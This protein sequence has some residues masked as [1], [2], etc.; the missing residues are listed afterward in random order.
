MCRWVAY[1]GRPVYLETWLTAPCQSLVAQSRHCREAKSE[2]NADGF[3]VGWY[4]GR[5][6]PG[7]FRDIRPAWSDENLLSL[8]GQIRSGLFLAHVRASTGTP[9]T[10]ANCHPFNDGRFLFMHNGQIG[11]Y[12][13]LRRRIDM[14]LPEERYLARAGQTDSE[15]LFQLMLAE[16]VDDPLAAASRALGFVEAVMREAGEGEALRFTAAFS[17]GQA[18]HAIRYASDGHPP[19][20][21]VREAGQGDVL[22]VSEPLDAERSGWQAVPPQSSVTV[23][24]RGISVRPFA[25]ARRGR[26]AA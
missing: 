24:D 22:L 6:T 23:D 9:A 25:V 14:A 17:D 18:L 11:G 10:R 20:L 7:I 15:T 16:G 2:I 19:T 26:K 1:R 8:A 13:R 5:E 12:E 3:G 21:Y 4:G